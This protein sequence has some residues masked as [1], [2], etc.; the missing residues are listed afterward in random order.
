MP[1]RYNLP[2]VFERSMKVGDDMYIIGEHVTIEKIELVIR[3]KNVDRIDPKNS[4][5]T[6][7]VPMTNLETLSPSGSSRARRSY[8]AFSFCL[9]TRENYT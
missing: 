3:L 9:K 4:Q 5:F 2:T 7:V 8:G 1:N 6:V